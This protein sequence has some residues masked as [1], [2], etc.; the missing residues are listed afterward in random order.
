VFW[1]CAAFPVAE[2][3]DLPARCRGYL[4]MQPGVL[5]DTVIVQKFSEQCKQ[6]HCIWPLG[7]GFAVKL[8]VTSIFVSS[9]LAVGAATKICLQSGLMKPSVAPFSNRAISGS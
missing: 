7:K 9:S 8:V 5:L 4:L 6:K 3:R 1:R 2:L